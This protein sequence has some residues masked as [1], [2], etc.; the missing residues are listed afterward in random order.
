MP[1]SSVH[2][3]P[4]LSAN[5]R[6]YRFLSIPCIVVI[7]VAAQSGRAQDQTSPAKELRPPFTA[8]EF[9][10]HIEY[11]A[12]DEL[13]GRAPGS[14]GWTKAAEYMVAELQADGFKPLGFKLRTWYQDFPLAEPDPSSGGVAARNILAVLPGQGELSEEA[15]IV[16][17]HYDHIGQKPERVPGEDNIFNGADD[18]ASGVAALLLIA[19]ALGEEDAQL[20][21]SRRA[22]II[23]SFD[24]EEQGLLGARY[25]VDHPIWPLAKTAAVINFD[26]IGR[27]WGGQFYAS[28]AETGPLL[29]Q[30]VQKAARQQQMVVQTNFGGHGRSDHSVFIER[31]IPGTHFFT[32]IH[33]DYHGVDDEADRINA[34]GGAL[35]AW[36]G[37][38]LV[39]FAIAH[40]EPIEFQR[41]APGM[42]VTFALNFV[43]K[44]GIV[45]NVNAQGGRYPEILFVVPGSHA[46]KYGLESGDKITAING[47]VFNRI[48]DAL[49]IF[50]QLKLEDGVKISVLRDGKK[51]QAD[52]PPEVFEDLRGPKATPLENGKY[53]VEFRYQAKPGVKSVHLA[54]QFNDWQPDAL[55]M[56]GP[57]SNHAF[58][59]QLELDPGAYEYKFVVDGSDWQ[60]D[61][62]NI[63]RV[64][65]DNNSVVW[66]GSGGK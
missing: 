48:E 37:Y 2:V 44:L 22:V 9:Q 12:S 36:V 18:N 15:V 23:A 61:P 17:A 54:G 64:G 25:Y 35:V 62:G 57:D 24:A 11:L 47:L 40:P 65:N 55:A 30:A 52:I 38:E 26:C 66:V 45:P 10:K 5:M 19:R 63:Y 20:P 16:C 49:V 50:Q 13:A 28:D 56:A 51:A 21:D 32:G 46:A 34:E 60:P 4:A 59:T 1:S 6:T 8:A 27:L 7:L 42:D 31:G 43:Q 53:R 14:E 29:A 39:R 41:L 58:T 3:Q 33:P